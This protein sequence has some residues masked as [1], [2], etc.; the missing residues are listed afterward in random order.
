MVVHLLT[1]AEDAGPPLVGFVVSKAIGNAV[2]RNLV[3]RRLRGAARKHLAILPDGA[4]AVVR[5][6]PASS[7]SSYARLERDVAGGFDRAVE[8]AGSGAGGIRP[9]GGEAR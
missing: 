2:R 4:R 7:D 8:R 5:A 6:L 9:S 1:E 3:K